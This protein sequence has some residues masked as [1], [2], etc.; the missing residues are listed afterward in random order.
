LVH[1]QFACLRECFDDF[2][3]G[4]GAIIN[5][6]GK[7]IHFARATILALYGDHPA[8]VK[9][10][11]TGS[12]CPTCFKSATHFADYTTFA[13]LRTT[14]NMLDRKQAILA[15]I[16]ARVPGDIAR[17]RKEAARQGLNLDIRNGWI[18]PNGVPS[19]MGPDPDK[20]NV[21][22]NSPS[23]V[24][25]A[26]DEGPVEKLS[27]ATVKHC[28][29]DGFDQH[30]LNQLEVRRYIDEAF[31]KTYNER[32]LNS[33]V[34]VNGRDCFQL[35]P[36]GVCGYLLDKR[37]LNAKWYGPL[38]DQLQMVLMNSNLLN[39]AHKK[40]MADLSHMVRHINF[41]IRQPV[42][43]NGGIEAYQEYLDCFT[44]KLIAYTLVFTPSACNSIKYHCMSHWGVHRQQLGCASMEYSLERAL[45]DHFT[46]FWGLTN[47]GTH[48]QGDYFK[49]PL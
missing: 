13:P 11:L 10:T 42:R 7:P 20:D 5:V 25:H 18:S 17:A 24:L 33:N 44:K 12:S 19:C 35:F 15:R 48:G 22:A 46:R 6:N 40:Q 30:G 9:S 28:I 39:P 27:A 21:H 38:C 3:I 37:R 1:Q 32:P 43:K 23:L 4:G 47:H 26:W 8:C 34:E 2:N 49:S 41:M 31:A 14:G 29:A 36:H 45:G 16:G